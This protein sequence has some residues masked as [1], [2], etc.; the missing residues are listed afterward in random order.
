MEARTPS[1]TIGPFFHEG[2]RWKDG[3][4]VSFAE[5]GRRIVLKG[6]GETAFFVDM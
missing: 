3:G 5:S 2:L 4:K 1:Q 6:P